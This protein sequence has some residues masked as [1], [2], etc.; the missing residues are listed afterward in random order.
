V[1]VWARYQ[2]SWWFKVELSMNPSADVPQ[3]P[4]LDPAIRQR[5]DQICS[6]RG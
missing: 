3:E 2:P 4:S 6:A 5:V 1:P